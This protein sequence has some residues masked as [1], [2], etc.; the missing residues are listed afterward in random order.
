MNAKHST[1]NFMNLKKAYRKNMALG[2]GISAAAHIILAFSAM[3]L[4]QKA[5]PSKAEI[6]PEIGDKKEIIRS[7]R[8]IRHP[9]IETRRPV[10]QPKAGIAVPA[11]DSLA[12]KTV[13]VPSQI[14]NLSWASFDPINSNDN[15]AITVDVN[16]I[17]DDI[18]PLPDTFI[19]F[20]EPPI[21]VKSVDPV[22]PDLARRAGME[23]DIW[24]NALIDKEGKV[25]DVLIAKPAEQLADFEK[26]ATD[27]AYGGVW[28]PA[29]ANGQ[30]TAVWI[31]YKVSFRLR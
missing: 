31:T 8:V 29:I 17:L 11:P 30:P 10:S 2:F 15:G 24:V 7:I 22:Y 18:L 25:R 5:A 1:D 12:P 3:I 27:A 20:D 13:D 23:A 6:P 26:S 19:P 28:R 21:P 14:E 9:D 16:N 4:L